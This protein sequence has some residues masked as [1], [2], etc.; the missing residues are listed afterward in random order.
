MSRQARDLVSQVPTEEGR[1]PA[2]PVMRRDEN[3][4]LP[5]DPL[6][7]QYRDDRRVEYRVIRW[8]QQPDVVGARLKVIANVREAELD[9]RS[10]VGRIEQ[11]LDNDSARRLDCFPKPIVIRPDDDNRCP[12]PWVADGG[13]QAINHRLV[14]DLQQQLRLPHATT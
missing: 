5:G 13:H 10:H 3:S 8:G 14:A 2:L 11:R 6:R 9:A 7:N 1:V 4:R 12:N